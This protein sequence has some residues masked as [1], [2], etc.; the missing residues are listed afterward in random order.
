[1]DRGQIKEV[2]RDV[3]G[4]NFL[5]KDLGKWVSI[6]CPLAPWLHSKGMDGSPSAG[7]SVDDQGSSGFHCAA[8][9][10]SGPFS[11]L[12][13]QYAEFSGED[14]S[15]LIEE[16]AEGEFLGPRSL[17]SFDQL[18]S[19]QCA[20]QAMP[21][22][23]GIYMDLYESAVGH[24]YLRERGISDGTARKLELLFDP[25]DTYGD[26]R[27]LFPVRGVDGLL[28]GF[29]GRDTSGKSETKVRDYFGLSKAQSVLGAHLAVDANRVVVV[30][31]LIDV[32]IVHEYGECGC[33]VMHATM[34][35]F[36]RDIITSLAKPTFLMYDNDKAGTDG[37]RKA[38]QQLMGHLPVFGTTY[39]RIQID[40]RSEQG[41]HWLKDPGEMLKEEMLDMIKKAHLL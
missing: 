36:Q 35:D 6:R 26:P 10:T 15:D 30:E 39:P 12:L 21:I 41:W 40:D 20:E 27:I 11:R 9:G 33:G 1:M 38:A 8:Q 13:E 29:S 28:Y 2:L 17:P 24:P 7:I 23:E 18:H 19:E 16:L 3:F 5:M 14:L 32:A 22:D 34:T 37:N 25:A 4:R 31:G